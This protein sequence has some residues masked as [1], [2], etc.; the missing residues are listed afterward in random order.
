MYYSYLLSAT[1]I[2]I[3]KDILSKTIY[4]FLIAKPAVQIAAITAYANRVYSSRFCIRCK[5]SSRRVAY[6][7]SIPIF[8][9]LLYI[10]ICST[11]FTWIHFHKYTIP[12]KRRFCNQ[13]SPFG[14]KMPAGSIALSAVAYRCIMWD[15]FL[16]YADLAETEPSLITK[17]I[18]LK[19]HFPV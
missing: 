15:I 17:A 18:C 12:S 3:K 6:S 16:S 4:A 5:I 19:Q 14:A 2:G 9:L 11:H 13:I 8:S 7:C 1:A 10:R